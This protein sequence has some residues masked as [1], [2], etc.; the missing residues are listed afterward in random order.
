M[1]IECF[2]IEHD[3]ALTR[4]DPDGCLERWHGGEGRYWIDIECSETEERTR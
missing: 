1:K 3:G 2:Q 4:D